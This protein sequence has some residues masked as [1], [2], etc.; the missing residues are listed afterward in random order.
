MGAYHS[1][2][3]MQ[4]GINKSGYQKLSLGIHFSFAPVVTNTGNISLRN[5]HI[6]FVIG[7]GKNIQNPGILNHQVCFLCL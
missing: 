5:C 6:P 7:A 4:M 3:Q 2:F 1:G